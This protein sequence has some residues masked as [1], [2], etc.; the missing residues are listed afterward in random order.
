MAT[1]LNLKARIHIEIETGMNRTGFDKKEFKKL[2]KKINE[3]REVLE[4]AGICTH[5]AGPESIA[6][7][8]R[9]QRQISNYKRYVKQFAKN[10]IV[11]YR[12]HTACSAA[13]I[14]YT[15]TQMDMVRIGILQYG[16]WPSDE[17][18]IHYLHNDGEKLDP[19]QRVLSWKSQIMVVK[20]VKTGEFVSYGT[21]FLAQEDMTIAIVPVGYSHGYSRTL[22]NHGRVLVHGHRC[23][24]IGLVNM[25]MM[26]V[27]ISGLDNVKAGDE[28]VLIGRQ[29]DLTITV[30]SFSQMSDQLNYELLTRLPYDI[31]RI[32]T[33]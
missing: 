1:E 31:P 6:N 5:Y 19:L 12:K 11:P 14:T 29:G 4:I 26:I 2:F 27:D 21:T 17:T 28:V 30:H 9:V 16:F 18:R 20:Q 10:G 13:S 15:K 3:N 8:L 33:E 23:G 22:S 24:V 7:H 25:N 32:L